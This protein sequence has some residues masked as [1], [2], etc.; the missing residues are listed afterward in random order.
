MAGFKPTL[1][2]ASITS[3][4]LNGMMLPANKAEIK[5]PV[6]PQSIRSCMSVSI[7]ASID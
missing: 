1:T 4:E 5:S 2:S 3:S 6:Y 7:K